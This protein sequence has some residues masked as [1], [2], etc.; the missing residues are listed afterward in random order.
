MVG[1]GG[2]GG[3]VLQNLLRLGVG[4]ITAV[5]SDCFDETNLNRQV[6]SHE[7]NLGRS[8]SEEAVRQAA[9][10]N[11]NVAVEAVRERIGESN[12]RRILAGHDIVIDAVDNVDT[13]L[14]LEQTSEELGIPM[15]HGAIAGWRGQVAVILPGDGLLHAIYNGFREHGGTS[16][17]CG[18]PEKGEEL[19][20]GT[21]SFTPAMV[22]AL[23]TAEALKLLL[24]KKSALAGKL[25]T[26]DLWQHEYEIIG[27]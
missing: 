25:L 12:A 14:L 16:G 23:Q 5:D 24:H 4:R 2:L 6:L 20:T 10:I 21:P 1:C 11:S 18:Q 9:D 7:S 17:D 27:F 13:R 8:K 19:E 3:G 22:A 26:V 15:V